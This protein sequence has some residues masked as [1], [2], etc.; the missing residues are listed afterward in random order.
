MKEEINSCVI[1]GK[2]YE[3]VNKVEYT[4]SNATGCL[5]TRMYTEVPK[6]MG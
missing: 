2:L 6:V 1:D 3:Y 4:Y 5:N